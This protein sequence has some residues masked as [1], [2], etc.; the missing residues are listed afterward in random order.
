MNQENKLIL[1]IENLVV[2]YETED[3]VVR[4]LNGS[5]CN[6]ATGKRSAWSAKRAPA[7]P[8][9][10]WPCCALSPTRPASWNAAG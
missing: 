5:T 8:P 9:P 6:S 1:D 4:A 7:K 10:R 3:G 2:R